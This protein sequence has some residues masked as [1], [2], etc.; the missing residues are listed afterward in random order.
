MSSHRTAIAVEPLELPALSEGAVLVWKITSDSG[1]GWLSAQWETQMLLKVWKQVHRRPSNRLKVDQRSLKACSILAVY[2]WPFKKKQNQFKGLWCSVKNLTS[3]PQPLYECCTEGWRALDGTVLCRP[4]V[5]TLWRWFLRPWRTRAWRN[6][7]RQRT[8]SAP[9]PYC[10]GA[11][12][13]G[14]VSQAWVARSWLK[15]IGQCR[16]SETAGGLSLGNPT[17]VTGRMAELP[18]HFCGFFFPSMKSSSCGHCWSRAKRSAAWIY[19]FFFLLSAESSFKNGRVEL[20]E[21]KTAR[22][23]SHD[24][25][26]DKFVG[27]DAG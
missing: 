8:D 17:V 24:L 12:E 27:R 13:G 10:T 4:S 20:S 7:H 2:Q 3:V 21:N 15:E 1:L 26:E 16:K 14:E 18:R 25:S 6:R 23:Q 11:R 19:A 9:V 5:P 22:T